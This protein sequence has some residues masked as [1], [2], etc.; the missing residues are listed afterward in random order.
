VEGT[1]DGPDKKVCEYLVGRLQQGIEVVT[2]TLGDK[3]NLTAKCG[4]TAALLLGDR[5]CERV[6]IVWDLYPPWR[7]R[8][9]PCRRD[10]RE[11]IFGALLE[12]GVATENV[13]LVCIR[14]ELE[15]WLIAD[16]RALATAL[17]R[18]TG[19]APRITEVRR[20]DSVS[21]PKERLMRIFRE[22]AHRQYQ[23][24]DHAIKIIR[25]L[26]NLN[27]IRRSISFAR[28]ALKA[29]DRAL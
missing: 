22:H 21:K 12:A 25:E 19:R 28:F 14:E 27:K 3:R 24:Y 8:E 17:L 23:G 26:P 7:R 11:V 20:P 4:E 5:N 9:K 2:I 15:A 29:T 18:L 13:H 6:V 10:D 16:N 1:S